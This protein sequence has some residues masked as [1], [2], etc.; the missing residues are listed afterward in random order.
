[1]FYLMMHLTHFLFLV[2]WHQSLVK[3]NSNNDKGKTLPLLHGLLFLINYYV[4]SLPFL[5]KSIDI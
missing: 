4:G 1:M 5:T 3:V 2:I